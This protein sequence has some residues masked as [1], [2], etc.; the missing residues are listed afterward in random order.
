MGIIFYEL[1]GPRF[2]DL[3]LIHKSKIFDWYF[4]FF[5]TIDPRSSYC[6]KSIH[7]WWLILLRRNL[8]IIKITSKK[9]PNMITLKYVPNYNNLHQRNKFLSHKKKKQNKQESIHFLKLY[10]YVLFSI[11]HILYF[12]SISS[13]NMIFFFIL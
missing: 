9:L 3:K 5:K 1:W 13:K 8:P 4:L 10:I 12:A 6:M 2:L 11:M 7:F